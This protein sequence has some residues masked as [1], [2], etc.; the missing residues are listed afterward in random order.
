MNG[1][2]VRT[3]VKDGNMSWLEVGGLH[4]YT[5]FSAAHYKYTAGTPHYRPSMLRSLCRT[6][7]MAQARTLQS[8]SIDKV[9]FI[10]VVRIKYIKVTAR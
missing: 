6:L 5:A 7:A 10:I 3:V 4:A 9:I 1:V 8:K 2:G